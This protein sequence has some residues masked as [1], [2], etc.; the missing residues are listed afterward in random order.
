MD[1]VSSNRNYISN[2][3]AEVLDK[4]QIKL[5]EHV[6]NLADFGFISSSDTY[7]VLSII[8][9]LNHAMDNAILFDRG[10]WNNIILLYNK[11]SHA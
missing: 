8:S 3:I 5:S 1:R 4:M 6:G 2:D 7:C 9:L 11:I 10:Q